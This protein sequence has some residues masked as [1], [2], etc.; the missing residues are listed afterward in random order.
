MDS[1]TQE[2]IDAAVRQLADGA[3]PAILLGRLYEKAYQVG[4]KEY[5]GR[6][7]MYAKEMATMAAITAGQTVSAAIAIGKEYAAAMVIERAADG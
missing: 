6:S 1:A 3:D 4:S 7:D 5:P 2:V